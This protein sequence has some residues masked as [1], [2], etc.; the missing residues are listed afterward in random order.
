MLLCPSDNS[1][2]DNAFAA[3]LISFA[4]FENNRDAKSCVLIDLLSPRSNVLISRD[5]L[6]SSFFLSYSLSN[7]VF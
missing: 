5:N 1:K 6:C 4:L 2:L 7:R 3:L